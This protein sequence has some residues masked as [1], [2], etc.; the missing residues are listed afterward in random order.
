MKKCS[1]C[2]VL[3]EDHAEKCEVCGVL[4]PTETIP[5]QELPKTVPVSPIQVPKPEKKESLAE[6][7]ALAGFLLSIGGLLCFFALPFQL[8]GL[9]LSV[10]GIKSQNRK[11]LSVT[12]I[13]FS[14]M[15]L[16]ATAIFLLIL[17]LNSESIANSTFFS[18]FSNAFSEAL[19]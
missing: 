16:L 2:G 5:K 18:E 15:G 12:G 14:V 1:V 17:I 11:L 3:N 8:I 13:I 6:K 10:A 4:F 9:C 7:Q 19:S